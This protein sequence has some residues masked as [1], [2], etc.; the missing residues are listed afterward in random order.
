MVI[1]LNNKKIAIILVLF[2]AGFLFLAAV[3][4]IAGHIPFL[5]KTLALIAA[6]VLILFILLFFVLAVK[7]K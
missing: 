3:L 2:V 5:G 1:I 4:G 6:A 7:R